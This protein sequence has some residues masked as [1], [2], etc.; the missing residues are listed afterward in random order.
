MH[1][2]WVRSF[3][4][5]FWFRALSPIV[6]GGRGSDCSYIGRDWRRAVTWVSIVVEEGSEFEVSIKN[7]F[8]V[9]SKNRV[10]IKWC[11]WIRNSSFFEVIPSCHLSVLFNILK[12]FCVCLQ[13]VSTLIWRGFKRKHVTLERMFYWNVKYC[14]NLK[15]VPYTFLARS[16]LTFVNF[17]FLVS[18]IRIWNQFWIFF[19]PYKS[20]VVVEW[21]IGTRGFSES[22]ITNLKSKFKKIEIAKIKKYIYTFIFIYIFIF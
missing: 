22:R 13:L 6:A 16:R 7:I 14:H 11:E 18:L 4:N 1:F 8:S 9:T 15:N 21:K 5:L 20:N 3:G 12:H 17:F 10:A 19:I 2:L